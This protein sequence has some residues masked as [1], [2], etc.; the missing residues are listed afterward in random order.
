MYVCIK[1]P[2]H[3]KVLS[4]D[5][6]SHSAVSD[7]LWPHGLKHAKLPCP[8]PTP[9]ACSN[10]CPLSWWCHPTIS[11]S[12]IPFT[13]CLQ[14]FL[15]SGSF[16]V[17][18]FFKSGLQSIGVSASVL[19]INIQDWFPLE[20]TDWLSLQ[21]KGLSRVF[22]NTSSKELVLQCSDMTTG[23]TTALTRQTL[24]SKVLS[25]LFNMQSSWS[26]IL[27]QGASVF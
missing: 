27:F 2:C 26:Q 17:S 19:P 12:V 9:G 18:K 8:S 20:W 1:D 3:F 10:S 25:L 14:S 23:K 5:Q 7:Y 11:F 13:S 4:S 24:V 21:S 6:F 16:S 22:A 15:P